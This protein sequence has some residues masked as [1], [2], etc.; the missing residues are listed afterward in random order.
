MQY[1]ISFQHLLPGQRVGSDIPLRM[2]YMQ[3][4]TGR[5]GEHIQ[6]I[7][8]RFGSIFSDFVYVGFFPSFLSFLAY[9]FEVH[10]QQFFTIFKTGLNSIQN[11]L[12]FNKKIKI[13][14]VREIV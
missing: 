9:V 2:S 13:S 8:F 6:N 5:I 12:S 14:I 1:I 11:P 4:C 7:E 3:S 10:L